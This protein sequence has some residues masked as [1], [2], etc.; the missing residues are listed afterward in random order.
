MTTE[1]IAR[2]FA[3]LNTAHDDLT[4]DWFTRLTR[5]IFAWGEQDYAGML[6]LAQPSWRAWAP[7]PEATMGW[8][9]RFTPAKIV[10]MVKADMRSENLRTVLVTLEDA[11]GKRLRVRVNMLREDGRW[12]YN[13]VSALRW[14]DAT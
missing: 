12:W 3:K 10:A 7:N 4:A 13:P 9:R 6:E 2:D 5:V 8:F 14:E 11:E 1:A